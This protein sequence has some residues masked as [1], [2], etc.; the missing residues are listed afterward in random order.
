[1]RLSSDPKKTYKK[2]K[3]MKT[4]SNCCIL[5]TKL[6]HKSNILNFVGESAKEGFLKS[7]MKTL[8]FGEFVFVF[9]QKQD[10]FWRI[11]R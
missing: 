10:L 8:R 5:R 3:F 7:R 1:M 2:I 6:Q 4:K 11:K 9:V